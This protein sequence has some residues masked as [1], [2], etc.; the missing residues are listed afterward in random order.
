MHVCMFCITKIC[1]ISV[2]DVLIRND[3]RITKKD[4]RDFKYDD[5]DGWSGHFPSSMYLSSREN[6]GLLGPNVW[7]STANRCLNVFIEIKK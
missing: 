5:T 6:N 3:A 1:S 7:V 4:L 2:K